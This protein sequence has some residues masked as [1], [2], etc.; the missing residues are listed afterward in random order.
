MA[1]WLTS[2]ALPGRLHPDSTEVATGRISA[3]VAVEELDRLGG[4]VRVRDP[5][6]AVWWVDGR[7]LNPGGNT[8][9]RGVSLRAPPPKQATSVHGQDSGR[10]EKPLVLVATALL[11]A[12]LLCAGLASLLVTRSRDEA[13]TVVAGT[14]PSSEGDSPI[15]SATSRATITPTSSTTTTPAPTTTAPASTTTDMQLTRTDT[16]LG[17]S[18]DPG[19]G[20]MSPRVSGIAAGPTGLW[21]MRSD[22]GVLYRVDPASDEVS[23]S[24]PVSDQGTSGTRYALDVGFGSV[25]VTRNDRIEVARV[26]ERSGE[27]TVQIDVGYYD[28]MVRGDHGG[29]DIAVAPDG[30]WI[31]IGG[32]LGVDV[33]R[34]DP[35]TDEVTARY[36]LSDEAASSDPGI[37][38]A[39]GA[40][41]VRYSW[42]AE[43]WI[44]RLEP[45]TGELTTIAEVSCLSDLVAHEAVMLAVDA[46]PGGGL[47]LFVIDPAT[48]DIIEQHELAS[49]GPIAS[50]G[51]RL[52]MATRIQDV[53]AV[54]W[55]PTTLGETPEFRALA[56]VDWV[57][58]LV[59]DDE[60]VWLATSGSP[61]LIRLDG[62]WGGT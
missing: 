33:A 38:A 36:R 58:G 22:T 62:L 39:H 35:T 23:L 40:L 48:G 34:I 24:V 55:W 41:W 21:A 44:V 54:V 51:E 53:P 4:W 57:T 43:G 50:D 8:V 32:F 20:A 1:G 31:V 5:D 61:A 37:V 18:A 47:Q 12:G 14:A 13:T 19:T 30:V 16:R 2:T 29:S 52:A 7:R 11:G 6:G 27:V 49:V 10:S 25:W 26:D 56:D 42:D 60:T 15:P 46:C 9:D 45:T 59:V 28:T 3:G 17:E